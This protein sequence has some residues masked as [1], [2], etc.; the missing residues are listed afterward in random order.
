MKKNI[1]ILYLL[2]IFIVFLSIMAWE[3]LLE[4]NVQSFFGTDYQPETPAEQWEYIK[5]VF[6]FCLIALI[7]PSIVAYKIEMKRQFGFMQVIFLP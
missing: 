5:T 1:A 7:V 3:F 6:V 2:T 4:P